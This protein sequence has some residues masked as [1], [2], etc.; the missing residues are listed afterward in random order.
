MPNPLEDTKAKD[1]RSGVILEFSLL[2]WFCPFVIR[3]SYGIEFLNSIKIRNT[4]MSWIMP[5]V[6]T[7]SREPLGLRQDGN[8]EGSL[9]NGASPPPCGECAQLQL[10]IYT[11]DFFA[12]WVTNSDF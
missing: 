11:R 9:S 7:Y 3:R 5:L 4:E 10:A 8:V 1:P 6:V 2:F 12:I